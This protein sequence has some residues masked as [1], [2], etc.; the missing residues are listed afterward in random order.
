MRHFLLGREGPHHQQEGS[1][2][3]DRP[4]P[5]AENREWRQA[6]RRFAEARAGRLTG[7]T[8]NRHMHSLGFGC[9]RQTRQRPSSRTRSGISTEPAMDPDRAGAP[10]HMLF[11]TVDDRL[12]SGLGVTYQEYRC[13]YTRMSRRR[14][15]SCSPR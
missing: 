14:S 11:S 6:T 4:D 13:V 10:T 12:G 8:I 5:P 2:S 9:D 3:L 15:A 1:P 7:S